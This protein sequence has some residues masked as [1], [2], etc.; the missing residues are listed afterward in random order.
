MDLR[1]RAVNEELRRPWLEPK[2]VCYRRVTIGS[3]VTCSRLFDCR[4]VGGSGGRE[5]KGP[6]LGPT[7]MN[8]GE[9]TLVVVELGV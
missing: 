2:Q 4:T 5:R 3:S 1:P 6:G 7:R 9:E 8:K